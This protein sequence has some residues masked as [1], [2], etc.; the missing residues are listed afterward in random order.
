MSKKVIIAVVVI[1]LI[2]LGYYFYVQRVPEKVE[3]P[4]EKF[5]FGLLLVG[6]FNDHGWSEAHFDGGKY[7]EKIIPNS[8]MIYI[9]KVNPADRPGVTITQLVDDLVEK[10]VIYATTVAYDSF[11][12]G[13]YTITHNNPDAD[14]N[15]AV[16]ITPSYDYDTIVQWKTKTN[17]Q[18]T[19]VNNS[20]ENSA[21]GSVDVVVIG[22]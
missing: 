9:D 12:A 17:T 11:A 10:N 3:L 20:G 13:E 19:L 4:A 2:I 7:V 1:G 6:P 14:T 22:Y 21:A 16:L 15:Y 5:I 8:K 18:V